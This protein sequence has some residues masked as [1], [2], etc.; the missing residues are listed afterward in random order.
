MPAIRSLALVAAAVLTFAACGGGDSDSTPAS[1]SPT[2]AAGTDGA[3]VTIKVFNFQ[4]DPLEVR[5]GETVTWTNEDEI[6]HTVTSGP[7]DKPDGSFDG[8]LADKGATFEHT[9]DEAGT[10]DYFCSRHPGEGMTAQV[11]VS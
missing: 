1:T 9:F 3:A 10:Y 7:R 6:L 4:P 8:Q 11:V 5:V 2:S